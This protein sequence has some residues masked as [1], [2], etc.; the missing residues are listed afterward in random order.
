MGKLTCTYEDQ[1]IS[2]LQ[3]TAPVVYFVMNLFR[4]NGLTYSAAEGI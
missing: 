3:V 2:K 4:L 1:N